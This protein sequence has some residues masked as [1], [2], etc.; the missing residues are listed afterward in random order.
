LENDWS[1][2]LKKL[3]FKKPRKPKVKE[4]ECLHCEKLFKP[5]QNRIRY[6]SK[7]C[8]D[9]SRRKV[10]RPTKKQLQREIKE[11][12]WLALGRKYNVTDSAVRKW[13]RNY[14]LIE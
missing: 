11:M 13:A 9:L 4:K 7:E 3:W 6:C 8:A 1:H 2:K 10:E 14:G 5:K 12:S